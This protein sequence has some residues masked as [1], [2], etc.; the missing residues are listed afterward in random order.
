MNFEI[1]KLQ[2]SGS[3]YKLEK[4]QIYEKKNSSEYEVEERTKEL[5]EST[6]SHSESVSDSPDNIVETS[7]DFLERPKQIKTIQHTDF[8]ERRKQI[9]RLQHK[10]RKMSLSSF[11]KL[12]AAKNIFK[13]EFYNFLKFL[14]TK[15]KKAVETFLFTGHKF[16]LNDDLM[17]RFRHKLKFFNDKQKLIL[18]DRSKTFMK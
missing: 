6:S 9:K 3:S 12:N 8:L 10:K 11:L 5:P 2:P 1:F 4:F 7:T 15:E 14:T 17:S 13:G 18:S 16:K